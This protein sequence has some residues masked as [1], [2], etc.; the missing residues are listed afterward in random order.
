MS[1][2]GWW[3]VRM[4][5]AA[6]LRERIAEDEAEVAQ[7]ASAWSRPTTNATEQSARDCIATMATMLAKRSAAARRIVEITHTEMDYDDADQTAKELLQALAH[8][9]IDHPDFEP[10]WALT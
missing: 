4:K 10:E 7:A 6:F 5:L 2:P 1:Y 3:G 9:Y 8:L